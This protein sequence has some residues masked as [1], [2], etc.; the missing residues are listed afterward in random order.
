MSPT[1]ENAINVLR[2][3]SEE[4][5]RN[6]WIAL[7]VFKALFQSHLCNFARQGSCMQGTAIA[8]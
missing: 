4:G 8:A 3:L 6:T 1:S 2:P 7:F 5:G